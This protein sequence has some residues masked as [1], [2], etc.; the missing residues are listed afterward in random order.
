LTVLETKRKTGNWIFETW[1]L[2]KR[3]HFAKILKNQFL[4]QKLKRMR[5]KILLGLEDTSYQK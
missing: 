4:V 3:C 2:E 1:E 5:T